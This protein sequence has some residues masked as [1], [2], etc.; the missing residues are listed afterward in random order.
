MVGWEV[1][2]DGSSLG[3]LGIFQNDIDDF[4]SHFLFEGAGIIHVSVLTKKVR[5]VIVHGFSLPTVGVSLVVALP[6]VSKSVTN[7][8][9]SNFEF[10]IPQLNNMNKEALSEEEEK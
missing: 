7:I 6:L 3:L 9:H 8:P 5:L 4:F 10:I 2:R 1:G